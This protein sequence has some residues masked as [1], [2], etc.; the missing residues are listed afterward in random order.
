M[1]STFLFVF[2]LVLFAANNGECGPVAAAAC[3]KACI[4]AAV[5]SCTYLWFL[6]PLGWGGCAGI[7]AACAI[8]CAATLAAPTP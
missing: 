1:N 3:I 2:V 4:D 8:A 5:A 7:S 6:G